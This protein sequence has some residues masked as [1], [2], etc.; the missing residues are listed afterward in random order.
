VSAA[1]L[2]VVQPDASDPSGRLGEWL[3][4]AG[5]DLDV[6]ELDA[7]DE[8]PADLS[9][10]Q[11]VL[12]MGGKTGALDDDVAP[13]LPAVRALLREAVSRELPTLGVCLGHQLLAAANGGQLRRNP[14]GPEIGAQLI[15]KRAAASIDPLFGALPITPDVLQWHFDE[16]VVL[17][18]GAIQLASS[19]GCDQQAFRLGRLAWGIQFHIE[20]TPDIVRAWASDDA[21]DL[22]EYDMDAILERVTACHDDLEQV[23]QPFAA[24][25]ADIVRDPGSVRLPRVVPTSTAQPVTDAAAI[26]AALAAELTESRTV[27]PTPGLRSPDDA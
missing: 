25:F 21:D 17:P 3:V 12:V 15:A 2:L 7:G 10:H 5:L 19:P 27:L 14:A 20:T 4:A 9:A 22:A 1:R 11:G 23:W 6:R 26:R 16:V 18:P 24:S 8:L 13:Y